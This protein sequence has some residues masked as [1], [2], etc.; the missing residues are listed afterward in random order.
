MKVEH[1]QDETMKG[2]IHPF[3]VILVTNVSET[4]IIHFSS[5]TERLPCCVLDITLDIVS[6]LGGLRQNETTYWKILALR[7]D[8]GFPFFLEVL[9]HVLFWSKK[10][11]N[12]ND[13]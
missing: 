9:S 1:I 10:C 12:E 4:S 5:A 11:D 6:G 7:R 13:K 3:I 8:L 2:C